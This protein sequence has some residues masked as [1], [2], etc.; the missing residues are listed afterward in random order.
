MWQYRIPWISGVD[1]VDSIVH[2]IKF[3]NL[4]NFDVY[5][6]SVMEIFFVSPFGY[7]HIYSNLWV[8]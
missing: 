7:L 2:L 6:C 5:A 1:L 8:S 3:Y 4:I